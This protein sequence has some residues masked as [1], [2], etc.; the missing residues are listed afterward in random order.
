MVVA[1]EIEFG[2]RERVEEIVFGLIAIHL[3]EDERHARFRR[4]RLEALEA[5]VRH[6]HRAAVR[7]I[8]AQVERVLQIEK[9]VEALG[10][11]DR[12]VEHVELLR[13]R[14]G[15]R[16]ECLGVSFVL[17]VEKCEAVDLAGVVEN[18]DAAH[19]RA[20]ARDRPGHL[21]RG[22][23]LRGKAVDGE[24]VRRDRGEVVRAASLRAQVPTFVGMARERLRERHRQRG[25]AGALDSQE[26]DF[27][28]DLFRQKRACPPIGTGKL[29][30]SWELRINLT[31]WQPSSQ[32]PSSQGPSS[33]Q[34]SSQERPS[35]REQPSSQ[36]PPS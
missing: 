10:L 26:Y 17:G 31:S 23:R 14:R 19:V 24:V 2:G 12:A 3:R 30:Q 11:L 34:P 16:A 20:V 4:K 25:L 15:T 21:A 9:Y 7:V 18:A 5:F 13:V 35:S 29:K 33:R 36:E 28:H 22:G 32:E 6:P 1:D 27:A 8:A